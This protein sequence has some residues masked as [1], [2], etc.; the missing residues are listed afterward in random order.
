LAIRGT[1]LRREDRGG[2]VH[3]QVEP[4]VGGAERAGKAADRGQRRHVQRHDREPGLRVTR[5]DALDG[6]R[7]LGGIAAAEHDLGAGTGE[8]LGDLEAE[9]AIRAGDQRDAAVLRRDVR[10]VPARPHAGAA[11][12]TP[13]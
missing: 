5:A 9:A 4:R 3:E 12:A 6:G 11:R 7:A 13:E 10:R 8:R 1:A 2:V